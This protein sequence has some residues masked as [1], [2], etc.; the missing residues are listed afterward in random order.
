MIDRRAK[1]TAEDIVCNRRAKLLHHVSNRR[2]KYLFTRDTTRIL[3]NDS[4]NLQF[5]KNEK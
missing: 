1:S 5:T 2:A 3:K 4:Q